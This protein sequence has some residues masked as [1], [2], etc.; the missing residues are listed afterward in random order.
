MDKSSKEI[1]VVRKGWKRC[2][3]DSPYFSEDVFTFENGRQM[4]SEEFS[5]YYKNANHFIVIV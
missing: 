4:N 1:E 5:D 2:T 3:E